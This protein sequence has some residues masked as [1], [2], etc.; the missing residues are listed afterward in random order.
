M[1]TVFGVMH[2]GG[3]LATQVISANAVKSLLELKI[4][5]RKS[6]LESSVKSL[7][8][9]DMKSLLGSQPFCSN[10]FVAMIFETALLQNHC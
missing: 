7:L 9:V 10:D 3:F 8:G 2:F 1:P 6:L 5:A 4:I